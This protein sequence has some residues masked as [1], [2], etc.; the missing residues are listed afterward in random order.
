MC[1]CGFVHVS[2]VCVSGEQK[3]SDS[4]ELEFQALS[5]PV[6]VPGTELGSFARAVCALNCWTISCTYENFPFLK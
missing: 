6:Q 1:V 2:T 4:L 3:A 5:C